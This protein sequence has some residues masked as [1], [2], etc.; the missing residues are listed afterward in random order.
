MNMQDLLVGALRLT[1]AQL[2][3]I[4]GSPYQDKRM[5]LLVKTDRIKG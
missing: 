4:S 2:D 3:A 5:T 1:A